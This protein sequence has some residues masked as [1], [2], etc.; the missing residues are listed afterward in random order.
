M[1]VEKT[2]AKLDQAT[3]EKKL[4]DCADILR[5]TLS[6]T[7]Y[8][9]YIFGMLFLKRINDQFQTERQEKT[10]KF[11]HL[12]KKA[13][14]QMLEDPTS[15]KNFF[16]PKPA[17]WFNFRDRN[18]NIGAELDQAFKVIE[19]E[20]R[21]VELVGVLT[22][23][24][25]NDRD[26]VP[27]SKINQ[28]IEIFDD[29]DL[30]NV[31][32]ESPDILGDAYMYLIKKFA[33]DG[34]Q[35]G[36]EFYTPTEIKDVM[37]KLIKPHQE[38]TIFDPCAGSGGFLVSAIEYV[39]AQGQNHRK[40]QLFGQETNPTTWAIAKLNMLLHDVSGTTIWKG[41]AIRNPQNIDGVGLKTFDMVL[42]NPPF[43]L[44]NWGREVAEKNDYGRFNYGVAPA[45]YGDLG[46]VQHMLASLNGKGI[47]A[48]VVPHG[49][50]FRSGAE[51][52]IRR[53]ILEDDLFEAVIGFPQN[54]FYGAAIPAAVII[55]NKNKSIDRKRKVL[56]IDASQGFV[57]DGNKNKLTAETID[58]IVKAYEAF[59]DEDR[60]ATL[61]TLEDIRKN[62]YNLNI[63]R[64]VDSS[65]KEAVVDINAVIARLSQNE[66]D[67]AISKETING[68]LE[69]LGF[70][71]I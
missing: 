71:Q 49:I 9:E 42:S 40:L 13:Q 19:E 3:L 7:R 36:G 66:A 17:W 33:D 61:A 41:D 30:S 65:T 52:I 59:S 54:L 12:P 15:Y 63:T 35:K 18:L 24:S 22:T 43:S 67:L 46:F 39:K 8:M 4:W 21:N 34:G 16:I 55:L 20:P 6:S 14:E 51:R 31:G 68:F 69:Q 1:V 27:D 11:K 25:Y 37:V 64:Y 38:L 53:G 28:L 58:H 50:L 32:L 62:D 48:A 47:M 60:F 56:F 5:G 57:K 29:L 2:I 26:R 10:D 45:S 44:K 70:E 23:F